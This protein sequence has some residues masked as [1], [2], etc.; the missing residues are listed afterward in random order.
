MVYALLILKLM[1]LYHKI[2]KDSVNLTGKKGAIP[3]KGITPFF[4]T[5]P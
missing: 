3:I 2:F 4:F 1:I 5:N